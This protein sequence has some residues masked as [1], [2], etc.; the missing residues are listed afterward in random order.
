SLRGID[1]VIL[2]HGYFTDQPY[3]D[4][5]QDEWVRIVD[6]ASDIGDEPSASELL[7]R[8]WVYT[9]ATR[10]GMTP[11]RRQLQIRG[12]D[13]AVAAV[14]PYFHVVPDLIAGTDRVAL[15]P[16]RLARRV[17]GEGFVRIVASP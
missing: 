15:L 10:E 8:D 14:T 3:L 2:P 4:V 5:M 9:L 17:A 6:S 7:A 1:G 13:V 12:L 16:R 11:A